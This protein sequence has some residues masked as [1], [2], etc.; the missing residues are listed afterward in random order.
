MPDGGVGIARRLGPL[1]APGLERPFVDG[2]AWIYGAWV[3]L[4]SA[5]WCGLAVVAVAPL[6]LLSGRP[7]RRQGWIEWMRLSLAAYWF[8]VFLVFSTLI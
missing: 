3:L 6:L 1:G 7:R 4:D 2:S 8:I 5:R